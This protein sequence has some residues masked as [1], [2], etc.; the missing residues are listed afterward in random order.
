MRCG[1][2]LEDAKPEAWLTKEKPAPVDV[3]KEP[4]PSM[5]TESDT[6]KVSERPA[7]RRRHP[8]YRL[9]VPI[10]VFAADGVL[11][12]GI[13]IEI[14]VSGISAIVADS[15]KVNDEV[16]LEPVATGK[17]LAVVRH[18]VGKIYGFEFL[19]LTAEQTRRITESCKLLPQ[20]RS[21]SL[22]I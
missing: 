8:R 12:P 19:N 6:Q 21:K 13:S 10:T 16:E 18:N 17:V 22:G 15:L 9:S 2:R 7:D 3:Y 20:Y 1:Q 11:I 4:E 14:S 5:P